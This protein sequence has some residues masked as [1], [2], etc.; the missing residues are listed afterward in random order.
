MSFQQLERFFW[1]FIT[2]KCYYKKMDDDSAWQGPIRMNIRRAFAPSV[3]IGKMVTGALY[4]DTKV[5]LLEDL[6]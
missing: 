1:E 4:L 3:A 6:S 2:D 5:W